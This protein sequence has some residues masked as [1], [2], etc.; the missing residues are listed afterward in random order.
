MLI[1]LIIISLVVVVIFLFIQ[2]NVSISYKIKRMVIA[3]IL[4]IFILLGVGIGGA[5][6][7]DK[8]GLD[9]I[10]NYPWVKYAAL[11]IALLFSI[12]FSKKLLKRKIN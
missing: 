2:K 8:T 5:F 12:F 7:L 3:Y 10:D 11:L 9:F 1:S 4:F 6:L